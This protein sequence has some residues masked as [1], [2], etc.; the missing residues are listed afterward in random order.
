MKTKIE[1]I[2]HNY[3]KD[4]LDTASLLTNTELTEKLI[5]DIYSLY[6]VSNPLCD[7]KSFS[8]KDKMLV[9]DDCGKKHKS[10]SA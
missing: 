7:C 1:Y 10:L 6:N 3:K 8:V 9:C 5:N 2:V 4:C